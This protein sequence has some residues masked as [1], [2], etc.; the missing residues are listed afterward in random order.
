MLSPYRVLDLTDETG[1]LC[2]KLLGDLRADVIK[3]ETP[4]GDSSRRLGP[5]FQDDPH[6]EKSL[7]W[8]AFNTNKRGITLDIETRDGSAIFRKLVGTAD[9][10]VESFTPGTMDKLNLAYTDLKEINPRIIV[11]SIT[12]FGQTGPYRDYKGED[13]V[14]W[15]LGGKLILTGD[16]DRAPV[17]ISHVPHTWLHGSADAAL[18]TA[19]A[20]YRRSISGEGQ[21]LDVSIQESV[22]KVGYLSHLMWSLHQ[23]EAPR[24]PFITTPPMDTVTHF[25]WPCKDGYVLFYPFSGSM[26]PVAT[27]P[28]VEFMDSEGMSD[29]F[30]MNLDWGAID[31]GQ[32]PQEEADRIAEYFTRFFKTKTKHELFDEAVKRGILIQPVYTAKDILEHPQ[33][34]ARGYWQ[35]IEHPELGQSLTYPGAFIKASETTC[36]IRRRAPLIGEHNIEIYRDELGLSEE[37]LTVFKQAGV[38]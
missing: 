21:H 3:I 38:I 17:R 28:V 19:M 34:N 23:R 18:G 14:C 15:A 24:G 37:Q 16:P 7:F 4:G 5:F 26:G 2:G 35:G 32:T 36:E 11:T 29:D 31:W 25:V 8:F 1:P 30:I 12:P 13:I 27:R 6:P 22:E 9:V 33:L 20:L 10:V